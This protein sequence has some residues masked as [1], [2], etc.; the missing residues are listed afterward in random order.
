MEYNVEENTSN[1]RIV[2]L[3]ARYPRSKDCLQQRSG[4]DMTEE[5]WLDGIWALDDDILCYVAALRVG[6]QERAMAYESGDDLM[7]LPYTRF[8]R[9]SCD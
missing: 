3:E 5:S 4:V 8:G 9:A 2:T 6:R 1:C 7:C